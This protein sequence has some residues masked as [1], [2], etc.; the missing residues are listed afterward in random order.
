[1]FA[2]GVQLP[3]SAGEYTLVVSAF[4]PRQQGPFELSVRSARAF[5]LEHIPPEG[6]GMYTKA[7]RGAWYAV[8]RDNHETRLTP[9]A[10]TANAQRAHRWPVDTIP[11]LLLECPCQARCRS[12]TLNVVPQ[13]QELPPSSRYRSSGSGC[14]L[15]ALLHSSP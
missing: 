14:R 2:G 5:S 1:M 13:S 15:Q 9:R 12:C 7:M 6:A 10:G 8:K 11:I 4:E 3:G